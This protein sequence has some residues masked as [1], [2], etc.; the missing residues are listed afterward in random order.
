MQSTRHTNPSS[1][2]GNFFQRSSFT[3]S[4]WVGMELRSRKVTGSLSLESQSA[5]A[6]FGTQRLSSGQAGDFDA[7]DLH[8]RVLLRM[9]VVADIALA[10][11]ELADFEFPVV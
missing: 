6:D 3:R 4:A 2:T 10:A 11:P 8:G 5:S 1:R 7:G 9:A